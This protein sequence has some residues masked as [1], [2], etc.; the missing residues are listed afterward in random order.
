MCPLSLITAK[1]RFRNDLLSCRHAYESKHLSRSFN[2][3]TC[4]RMTVR[5][6]EL[7]LQTKA[8]Q[9]H[10]PVRK[11]VTTDTTVLGTRVDNSTSS[12]EVRTFPETQ[13]VMKRSSKSTSR[14]LRMPVRHRHF[15]N[16][17]TQPCPW[18]LENTPFSESCVTVGRCRARAC[19]N[20]GIECESTA[21][22]RCLGGLCHR[23]CP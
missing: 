3:T 23:P 14:P 13:A 9:I 6:Q 15:A 17:S 8:C 20:C 10:A 4:L 18:D 22:S 16:R 1:R 7:R 19:H 12:V 2:T 5:R 21:V 11:I